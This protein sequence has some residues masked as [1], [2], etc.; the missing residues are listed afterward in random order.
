M[1]RADFVARPRIL[2]VGG[3]LAGLAAAVHAAHAGAQVTLLE[4]TGEVGG[5][6]RTREDRHGFRFNFGPHALYASTRAKLADLGVEVTGRAPS[7]YLAV[8]GGRVHLLPFGP[9]ALEETGLLGARDKPEAE[10][11]LG[12][13]SRADAED[14]A[15]APLRAWLDARVTAA[16][17]RSLVE[18]IARLTTLTHDPARLSTGAFV[19]QWTAGGVVY[20]D[21][22][23]ASIVRGLREVAEEAGVILRSGARVA[24]VVC[25]GAVRGV[26]LPDDES[27]E[28]DAVI[29]AVAPG[30]ASAL[31]P[32]DAGLATAAARAVPVETAWLDLALRRPPPGARAYG[33]GIGQPLYY[34]ETSRWARLAPDGGASVVVA[35]FL[36]AG[37]P[38]EA[39]VVRGELEAFA[40][41]LAP[42]WRDVVVEARFFPGMRAMEALPLAEQGGLPGRPPVDAPAT[43]GVFVAGDWVR[44]RRMLADGALETAVAAADLAL[45]HAR[46]RAVAG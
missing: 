39:A 33:L 38:V 34:A 21:G 4:R 22:G 19:A 18:A 40:D 32:G 13:L 9:P 24:E 41:T 1:R 5:R 29:L 37:S 7:E 17:V 2:V 16:P 45:A 6:A 30:S 27:I 10:R 12:A 15:A 8:D 42:G 43:P 44:S 26:R 20:P 46:G 23:W 25:A 3:G 36:R 28:A 14:L 35:R 31:V 11:I